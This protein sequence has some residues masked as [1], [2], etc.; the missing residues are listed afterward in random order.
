AGGRVVATG[1][2]EAIMRAPTSH[3][4]RFLRQYLAKSNGHSPE[5]KLSEA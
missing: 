2:P 4:G 3:T 5:R 1:T